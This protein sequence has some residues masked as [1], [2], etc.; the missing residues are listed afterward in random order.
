MPMYTL[1]TV[2]LIRSLPDS[3]TQVWYA[4]DATALG[5]V[6]H[7]RAWWDA[8]SEK[9]KKYG[10]FA[11]PMKTWLVTR[12]HSVARAAM[13]AF[14]STNINITSDGRPHLG[15]PLGTQEY[16]DE[17]LAKKIEQWSTELRSLSSIAES[18]PHAAYA[19]LTHGLSSKWSY[20]SRTIP[21]ISHHLENLES[22]LR[23]E[24]I[25]RFTGRPP[26]CDDERI[27]FALPAR[28][29]GLGLR[30]PAESAHNEFQSSRMVTDPLKKLILTKNSDY[31][32]ECLSAQL[33]AKL[34]IKEQREQKA[35]N[36]AKDL[37]TRLSVIQEGYGFCKR[38]R[39]IHLAHLITNT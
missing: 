33:E 1:A 13:Q 31:S 5:T 27:L 32:F 38:T 6:S 39:S 28:L 20:L 4:D 12:N 9:G 37:K 7:L 19:A 2:P 25:H 18:Q 21:G 16:T 26:P 23:L 34:K 14:E 35:Q 17:F 22:I 8:I 3:V 29:G 30:N 15:V 11:N 36:V 10:Y 24:L